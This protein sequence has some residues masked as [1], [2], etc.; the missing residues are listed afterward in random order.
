M[1]LT[2]GIMSRKYGGGDGSLRLALA[3]AK[4]EKA[5]AKGGSIFP[6][7]DPAKQPLGPEVPKADVAAAPKDVPP[8]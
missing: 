8:A 2:A 7:P 3:A 1:V 6:A 5:K 4:R